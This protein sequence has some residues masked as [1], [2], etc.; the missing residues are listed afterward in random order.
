M[1]KQS[2]GFTLIELM[3]VVAI[4]GILAAIAI[5]N[6]MRYQLRSKASERKTNVEAIFKA[7]EALRQSERALTVGGPTGQ[8]WQFTNAVPTGTPGTTKLAWTQ[9]NLVVSQTVDWV[10][11]GSTYGS[12][13][14]VVT[15][16]ATAGYGVAMSACGST[17]IDGD[18]VLA[19]DALWQP[20]LSAAGAI[21]TAPPDAPCFAGADVTAHTGGLA[22]G[23]IGVSPMGQAVQ[24]SADATF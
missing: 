1:K 9:A 16:G 7:E 23:A 8:Y 13:N 17:N 18:T 15:A 22:F 24:L 11:Q 14:A 10:V 5:P 21:T 3:I 19:A 2:K 6:F 12:Y 20:Q 4:I